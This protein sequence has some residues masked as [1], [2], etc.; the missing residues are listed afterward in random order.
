VDADV[1]GV[2]HGQMNALL[3]TDTQITEEGGSE[4]A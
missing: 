3:S 1:E 4:D 2:L